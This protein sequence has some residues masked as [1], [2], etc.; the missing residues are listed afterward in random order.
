MRVSTPETT[1]VDLVRFCKAAGQLD[2]VATV[3]ADLSSSLDPRKLLAAVKV[4]DDIPN[5]QR[6]GYILDEVRAPKVSV[7]LRD[8]VD[9]HSPNSV[10]LR[11]G[12]R[13]QGGTEDRRWRV[14]VDRPLEVET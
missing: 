5:V 6:L 2:N 13:A 1:A 8:W 7:P 12:R 9:R 11:R 10:P 3:I 4:V 14:L